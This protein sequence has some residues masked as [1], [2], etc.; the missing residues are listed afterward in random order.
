MKKMKDHRLPGKLAGAVEYTDCIWLHK[1][2]HGYDTKQS[3]V[4]TSIL[5]LWW[6][7]TTRLLPLL[8]G[9][10]WPRTVAPDRILSI[11]QINVWHL[12]CV[13]TNDICKIELLEIELFDHLTV[14]KQ[15]TV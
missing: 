2:C 15:M 14:C 4:E 7:W 11:D 9:S 13:Q 3:D 6:M 5:E 10:L 12:I 1:E 8:P